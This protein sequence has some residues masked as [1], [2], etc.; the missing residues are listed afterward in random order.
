MGRELRN[1]SLKLRLLAFVLALALIWYSLNPVPYRVN[2]E[3]PDAEPP[4]AKRR[5][6]R[7]QLSGPS[8]FL[9]AQG[10]RLEDA[11]TVA[12]SRVEDVDDFVWPEYIDG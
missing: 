10:R 8:R 3:K 12:A 2:K 1:K 4:E 11:T 5:E 7:P 9:Y 6:A